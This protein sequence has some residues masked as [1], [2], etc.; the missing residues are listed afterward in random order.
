M[1]QFAELRLE[2]EKIEHDQA[3][4]DASWNEGTYFVKRVRRHS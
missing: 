3:H 1:L 4:E 2:E